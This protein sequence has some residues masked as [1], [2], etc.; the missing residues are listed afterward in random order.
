MTGQDV[1]QWL[2]SYRKAWATDD[3]ADV[4]ALFTDDATYSPWPYAKPWA[5]RDAIV[6]KWIERGDSQRPWG[7]EHRIVAV[8]G[9]LGVVEGVTSYPAHGQDEA[10]EFKNLWLIHLTPDG[11]ARSFAEWWVERPKAS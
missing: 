10:T 4:A 11:R 1:E 8:D 9:D 6:S 5:G 2:A 3:P 7:F